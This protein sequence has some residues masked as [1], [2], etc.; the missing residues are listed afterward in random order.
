MNI[1]KLLEEKQMELKELLPEFNYKG[2]NKQT[3]LNWHKQSLKQVIDGLV[4][5]E[6]EK[7]KDDGLKYKYQIY[8]DRGY[9]KAKKDTISHLKEIRAKME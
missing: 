5:R 3:I 7:M 9:N 8:E 6:E 4:E 2:C 1:E